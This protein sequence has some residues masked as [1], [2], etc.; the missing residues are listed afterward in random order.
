MKLTAAN[1]KR[2][3]SPPCRS[4]RAINGEIGIFSGVKSDALCIRTEMPEK[5]TAK[6]AR[7]APKPRESADAALA[8]FPTS[9]MAVRQA[10]I[11]GGRRCAGKAARI[12]KK[13]VIPVIPRSEREAR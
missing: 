4:L 6:E 8:P 5:D 12:P 7:G 10:A 2:K 9:R 1:V 3:E 11:E 13:T